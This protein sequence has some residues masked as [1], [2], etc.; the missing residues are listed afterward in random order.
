[1]LLLTFKVIC[2]FLKWWGYY[3]KMCILR[4]AATHFS[5]LATLLRLV[6]I[7]L[8]SVKSPVCAKYWQCSVL[9][10]SIPSW[11]SPNWLWT[12]LSNE[13]K[14]TH[15]QC[16]EIANVQPSIEIQLLTMLFWLLEKE[17]DDDPE[18][19]C[20]SCECLYQRKNVTW[21]KLSDNLSRDVWSRLKQNID[22]NPAANDQMLC[23]CNYCKSGI[24]ENKL[25]SHCVLNGLDTVPIPP[26]LAKL[27]TW[28][29]QL[30]QQG[31]SLVVSWLPRNPPGS[32]IYHSM[33]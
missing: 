17:I 13:V 8:W 16:T 25:P 5:V 1:M 22:H 29:S 18:H 23:M 3:R 30:V 12:L 19:V 7:V 31:C 2:G 14:T 32:Q 15:E 26:E 10:T 4:W 28:S 33:I 6:Y 9:V 20:C 21:V 27:D 11:K 24:K